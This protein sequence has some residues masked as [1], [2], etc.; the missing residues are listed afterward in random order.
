M[1][2]HNTPQMI[3]RT[4][5][6]RTVRHHVKEALALGSKSEWRWWNLCSRF[7]SSQPDR[8][9]S[10]PPERARHI[11]NYVLSHSSCGDMSL[12]PLN[13]LCYPSI[14]TPAATPLSAVMFMRYRKFF[15]LLLRYAL[16]YVYRQGDKGIRRGWLKKSFCSSQAF[17]SFFSFLPAQFGTHFSSPFQIT[18]THNQTEPHRTHAYKTINVAFRHV[19]DYRNARLSSIK[20]E[21]N[22]TLWKQLMAQR[23]FYKRLCWLSL[24]NG[25]CSPHKL[26]CARYAYAEATDR[27]ESLVCSG[28]HLSLEIQTGNPRRY[29]CLPDFYCT[30]KYCNTCSC[31]YE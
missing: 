22:A 31:Y 7:L 24:L 17:L 3:A 28:C 10:Y 5:W 27:V 4:V 16:I 6:K 26:N 18:H 8:F 2:T 11:S 13:D 9:S 12:Q 20:T 25:K 15:C 1:I 14:G 21:R 30:Y 23:Y 29:E 19:T